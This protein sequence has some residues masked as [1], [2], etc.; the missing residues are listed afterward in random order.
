VALDVMIRQPR[1]SLAEA[2]VVAD[3]IG[4]VKD[5]QAEG[6]EDSVSE[7]EEDDDE[8]KEEI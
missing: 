3:H 2:V 8:G 7:N 5:L 4:R 1:R 6:E